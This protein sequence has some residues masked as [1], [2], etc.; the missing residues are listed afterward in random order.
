MLCFEA[1][2]R[3]VGLALDDVVFNRAALWP[4][5]RFSLYKDVRHSFPPIRIFGG[6]GG[7]GTTGAGAKE[8]GG[9]GWAL[10]RNANSCNPKLRL[11]TGTNNRPA[12][13]AGCR[14]AICLSGVR[15]R[16][17]ASR[18]SGRRGRLGS[19]AR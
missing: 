6:P 5:L 1:G 12:A 18:P 17:L 16:G 15:C 7:V 19:R 11:A 9:D 14:E 4:P 2:E 3:V 10:R 8:P 13:P